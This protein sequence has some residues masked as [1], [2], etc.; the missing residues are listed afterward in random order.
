MGTLRIGTCS[1]KYDSWTGLVYSPDVGRNHLAQYARR[2]D[3]VEVDQWFWSLHGPDSV[4]LPKP[5][6]VAEYAAAVPTGFR[7]TVKAPNSLTLTH[8]YRKNPGDPL[9]ENPHFLS[10]ELFHEFLARLEPLREVLGP[11]MLQF[12]YLN[13]QKM[14]SAKAF[15]ERMDAFLA[16]CR[17]DVPLGIELRNPNWLDGAH[18]EWLQSRRLAHV[19]LDGYYMPPAVDIY[20]RHRDRIA[21]VTVVRLHGPD[22]QGIEEKSGGSWDRILEPRDGALAEVARMVRELQ[23]REVDVYLNVNNHYEGCAPLTI[24]RLE[25]MINAG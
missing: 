24:R 10:V 25:A 3:T 22:R 13:R 2:Y 14:P 12:E 19:F 21:D 17:R 4:S 16:G 1:W 11:V 7:F 8:F 18:F 5:E 9:R 15:R 6:T 23:R 20:R